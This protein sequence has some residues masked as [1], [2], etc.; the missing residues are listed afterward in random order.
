MNV[1]P[2]SGTTIIRIIIRIKTSD[3][4]LP[5]EYIYEVPGV[6]EHEKGYIKEE[7]GTVYD[8]TQ[9][10]MLNG[11]S[12]IPKVQGQNSNHRW[13]KM[14]LNTYYN[15]KYIYILHMMPWCIGNTNGIACYKL[16]KRARNCGTERG[17]VFINIHILH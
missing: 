15:T 3:E 4:A 6:H 17:D 13:T 7:E 10:Y 16:E 5:L 14:R 1:V 2:L 12:I 11:V 8:F 9:K